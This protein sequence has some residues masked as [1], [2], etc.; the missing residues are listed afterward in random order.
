M[1]LVY[2]MCELAADS[3]IQILI[4]I[5]T[6][7]QG[8]VFILPID[9]LSDIQYKLHRIVILTTHN[10]GDVAQVSPVELSH[11]LRILQG[12]LLSSTI[13]PLQSR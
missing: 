4:R 13:V 9:T 10:A 12:D 11:S 1:F 3:S 8:H 6:S 7:I 5:S 2:M